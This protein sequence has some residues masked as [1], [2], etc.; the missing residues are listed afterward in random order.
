MRPILS[1]VGPARVIPGRLDGR[2]RAPSAGVLT[3]LDLDVGRSAR[4]PRAALPGLRVRLPVC[5]VRVPGV[6][7]ARR[8]VLLLVLTSCGVGGADGERGVDRDCSRLDRRCWARHRPSR[9]HPLATTCSCRCCS[10]SACCCSCSRSAVHYAL[11][12]LEAVRDAERRRFELEGF[13]A[14]SGGLRALRAQLNPH[15]LYNSLNSISALTGAQSGRRAADVPAPRRFSA[16]H[17]EREWTGQGIRLADEL[18][19]ADRGLGHRA[20]PLRSAAAGGAPHQSV[21]VGSAGCRR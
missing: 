3:R 9:P 13:D 16:E 8:G 2:R 20:D 7:A 4:V 17:V 19:L 6:S 5:V 11:L 21:R 10:R 18:A 1:R 14:Q 15:F 12:A